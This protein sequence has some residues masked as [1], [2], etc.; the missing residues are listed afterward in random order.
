MK[1][2]IDMDGVM[3]DTMAEVYKRLQRVHDVCQWNFDGCC[4]PAGSMSVYDDTSVFDDA[5]PIGGALEGITQL[6]RDGHDVAFLSAPWP[7]NPDSA[8]AK[9]RWIAKHGLP[10]NRLILAMD[11]TLV[12]GD[13]LIDDR[14]GLVGPWRHVCYP[15]TWNTADPNRGLSWIDGL[16]DLAVWL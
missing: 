15:Q 4:L 14:P 6:M 8:A 7:T 13:I 12:P 10:V 16:A 2:L 3:V 5:A 1:I 9:Y 11:K